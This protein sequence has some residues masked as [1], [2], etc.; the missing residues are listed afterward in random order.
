SGEALYR[1]GTAANIMRHATDPMGNHHIVCQGLARF[2][3]REF[4]EDDN[5]L[6]C[7]KVDWV[8]EPDVEGDKH[9]DARMTN[10]RNRALEAVKLMEQQPPG[11][12][13]AIGSIESASVLADAIAGYL[14][15]KPKEKQQILETVDIEPRLELVQ[16]FMD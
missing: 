2:R 8:D 3:V 16:S 11:L 15:L 6:L 7:A 9:V 5:G 10:L 1:I 12:A 13:N 4:F 14:G